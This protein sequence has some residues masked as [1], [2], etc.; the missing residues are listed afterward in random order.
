MT[1]TAARI[2]RK[3]D[4]RPLFFILAGFSISFALA[5]AYFLNLTIAHGIA[6]ERG[7]RAAAALSLKVGGLEESYFKIKSKVTL[8]RAQEYGFKDA[9]NTVVYISRAKNTETL[10]LGTR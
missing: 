8:A 3:I 5:Y 10:S 6:V 4:R 1:R 9:G 7:E 2:V